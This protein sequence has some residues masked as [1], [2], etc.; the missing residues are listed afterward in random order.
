MSDQNGRL[1]YDCW[2]TIE[3]VYNF[4]RALIGLAQAIK[5]TVTLNNGQEFFL[6]DFPFFRQ[7]LAQVHRSDEVIS[8][9]SENIGTND[10]SYETI[11]EDSDSL[12]DYEPKNAHMFSF[13]HQAIGDSKAVERSLENEQNL[14]DSINQ[15]FDMREEAILQELIK[16]EQ[17]KNNR[18]QVCRLCP[19][20]G[21]RKCKRIVC[22]ELLC[23]ANE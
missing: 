3:T 6:E 4:A 18:R 17:E 8:N 21:K 14:E 20:H 16:I 12:S 22:E 13:E 9:S 5:R 1:S 15:Y 11:S 23:N 7:R 2:N 10:F 19:I